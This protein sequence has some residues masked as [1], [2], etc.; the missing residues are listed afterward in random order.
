M[1]RIGS[2]TLYDFNKILKGEKGKVVL[3]DFWSS[4]CKPCRIETPYLKK[5]E[6]SIDPSKFTIISIDKKSEAWEKTSKVDGIDRNE[7]NY[8]IENWENTSLHKNFEIHAIPRYLLF[9]KNGIIVDDDA[10]KPS[11]KELKNLLDK[12]FWNNKTIIQIH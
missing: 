9:D 2:E 7:H 5:L 10:P 4:W 8:L 11:S 6:K 3:V 12:H 1:K